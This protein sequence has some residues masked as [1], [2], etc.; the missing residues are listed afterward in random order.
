MYSPPCEGKPV[1]IKWS[2]HWR[3]ADWNFRGISSG[4]VAV[5][6]MPA[7]KHNQR[8]LL[9]VIERGHK[10]HG[11]V[12]SGTFWLFWTALVIDRRYSSVFLISVRD[13][14]GTNSV[15]HHSGPGL[16]LRDQFDHKPPLFGGCEPHG[17]EFAAAHLFF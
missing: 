3:A 15:D 5:G 9:A 17:L 8:I 4:H 14:S 7:F 12:H 6:F 16:M 10:A 11:Y 13:R 1:Q 2:P